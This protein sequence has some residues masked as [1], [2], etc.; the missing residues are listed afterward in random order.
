MAGFQKDNAKDMLIDPKPSEVQ[1]I[2]WTQHSHAGS[3]VHS[4]CLVLLHHLE[5]LEVIVNYQGK[6]YY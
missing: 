2:I 1:F 3:T 6:D 5:L 4:W